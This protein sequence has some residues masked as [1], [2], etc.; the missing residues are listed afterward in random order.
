M[1]VSYAEYFHSHVTAIIILAASVQ[2]SAMMFNVSESNDH[3]PISLT[4]NR[5]TVVSFGVTINTV[6]YTARGNYAIIKG[7][8]LNY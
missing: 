2:F 6:A 4:V 8:I 5:L 7:C 1:T 3:Q